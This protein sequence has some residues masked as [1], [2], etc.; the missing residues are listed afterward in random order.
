MLIFFVLL[1][2]YNTY[3]DHVDDHYDGHDNV[4]DYHD[5]HS[6]NNGSSSINSNGSGSGNSSSSTARDATRLELPVRPFSSS[7]LYFSFTTLFI[8]GP[9]KMAMAATAAWARDATSRAVGTFIF[10]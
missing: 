6:S 1:S 5:S 8:L 10:F 3:F 9:L 2:S 7:I 4:H